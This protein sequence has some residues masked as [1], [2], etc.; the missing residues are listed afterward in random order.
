MLFRDLIRGVN[1]FKPT[2]ERI[3]QI[4]K[5]SF[6]KIDNNHV[7]TTDDEEIKDIE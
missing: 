1:P 5:Y 2:K 4:K 7:L 3:Q 6:T